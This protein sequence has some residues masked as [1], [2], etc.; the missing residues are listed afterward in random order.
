MLYVIAYKTGATAYNILSLTREVNFVV[1]FS[2]QR[3]SARRTY[4]NLSP[5]IGD[6]SSGHLHK[7][8]RVQSR[9]GLQS[10]RIG[11]NRRPKGEVGLDHV[12]S[13]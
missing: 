8:D 2:E 13:T 10:G 1:G 9:E 3:T 5:I 12:P 6:R 11:S 7:V 4:N